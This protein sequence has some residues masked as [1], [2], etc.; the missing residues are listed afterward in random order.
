[1]TSASK[2]PESYYNPAE[3]LNFTTTAVWRKIATRHLRKPARAERHEVQV[4]TGSSFRLVHYVSPDSFD[5]T[6]DRGQR[7]QSVHGEQAIGGASNEAFH[8]ADEPV[9]VALARCLVDDILVVVISNTSTQLFVVHLG[10]VLPL[11]PSAR[12]LV[13]IGHPEFPAV[14][15]P[16]DD[17]AVG[18]AEEQFEQ[19]LPQLDRTVT[20]GNDGKV[21]FYMN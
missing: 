4:Y 1:M 7:R 15:G 10:F 3:K 6:G 11:A 14:A 19:E 13:R 17:V 20:C 2:C 8:L 12:H 16:R 18:G 21:W 5:L 9:N